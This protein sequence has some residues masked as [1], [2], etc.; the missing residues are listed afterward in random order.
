MIN[1]TRD[2]IRLGEVDMKAAASTYR[3]VSRNALLLV[4]ACPWRA[5]AD[6]DSDQAV[7]EALPPGT[8]W[9]CFHTK[10]EPTYQGLCFRSQAACNASAKAFGEAWNGSKCTRQSK[11]VAITYDDVV[12]GWTT[13]TTFYNLDNCIN[14]RASQKSRADNKNVS[15]CTVVG[16]TTGS[17][18][19]PEAV[20]QG[21]GWFCLTTDDGRMLRHNVCRRDKADCDAIQKDA[22]DTGSKVSVPCQRQTTAFVVTDMTGSGVFVFGSEPDC[23][24]ALDFMSGPSVCTKQP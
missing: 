3:L 24:N 12:Q 19:R 4:L 20:P 14:G 7:T 5:S 16:A 13:H 2:E 22:K 10:L 1:L 17:A 18:F 15:K 6:P 8:E 21:K 11:A 9:W 23:L